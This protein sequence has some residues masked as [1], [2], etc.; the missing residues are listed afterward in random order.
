MTPNLWLTVAPSI[1]F[2]M[3]YGYVYSISLTKKL[4]HA[5]A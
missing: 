2:S 1:F 4:K 5:Q 3:V